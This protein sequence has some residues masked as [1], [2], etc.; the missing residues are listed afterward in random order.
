M[1][2]SPQMLWNDY[3]R[4]L[5]PLEVSETA[6]FETDFGIEKHIYFNG[7]ATP[8][9]CTRIYARYIVPKEGSE[10]LVIVFAEPETDISKIDISKYAKSDK[11][12]MFVDYA[13]NAF[14]HARFTMYPAVL[15]FAN[16]KSDEL[17]AV[18]ESPAKNPHY[19]WTTVCLRSIT[20]AQN[21]GFTRVGLIGI[22]LG[23]A[24]TLR[25]AAICDYPVCAASF[26]SPGFFPQSDDPELKS[27]AVSL[28][29]SG[30]SPILKVPFLHLCCSNDFDSSLD[31]ISK[32]SY[33]A[34]DKDILYISKRSDTDCEKNILY[35]SPR[36]DKGFNK[37]SV[38]NL[39]FFVDYY[40]DRDDNDDT[41]APT[42]EFNVTGG[43]NKMYF[44]LKCDVKLSKVSVYV[45]HGVSNPAYRNWRT[46]PVE[47]VGENEYMG[48][49]EV[50]SSDNPIY[51]FATVTTEEGFMYSTQVQSK[52]PS[53]LRILPSTITKRRLIYD[54]D[55]GIDDFFTTQSDIKPEIKE[56]PFSINGIC[57]E[58]GLCTYKLGDVAYSGT[59][60]SVLQL[61]MY[62]PVEQ[63]VTFSVT[64]CDQFNTYK[65]T[66]H[67]SPDTDWT[68]IMISSSDLKSQDGT[69]PGWHRIIFLRIDSREEIIINTMLWV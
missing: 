34:S 62:S 4:S 3:D 52:I 8:T 33:K 42:T 46:L 48:Y 69:F 54:S 27:L 66:K 60:D 55:M 9:G 68:K 40:L 53:A 56:G 49:S 44:S 51:S 61:L 11:A 19:V 32:L 15:S 6:S 65:T 43:D 25:S 50:Y 24:L 41:L 37:E 35:I 5:L 63:D 64:D 10:K 29:V 30:Y 31:A 12:V 67:I 28:D 14:D 16:Y 39:E 57:S 22:S 21:A 13:G 2:L 1:V 38:S 18:T 17:F 45:S 47:K 36:S 20:F 26:F 58:N 7:E 23:G 59:P